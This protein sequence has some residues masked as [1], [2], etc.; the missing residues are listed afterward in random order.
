M[1]RSPSYPCSG[2]LLCSAHNPCVVTT[3]FGPQIA[4]IRRTTLI[5]MTFFLRTVWRW[6]HWVAYDTGLYHT[7]RDRVRGRGRGRCG[8]GRLCWC[9]CAPTVCV[10]ARPTDMRVHST[11]Q[12][13]DEL[14]FGA[15]TWLTWPP[16]PPAK[17]PPAPAHVPSA[18][19]VSWQ[20]ASFAAQRRAR[21]APRDPHCT[22]CSRILS[23]VGAAGAGGRGRVPRSLAHGQEIRKRRELGTGSASARRG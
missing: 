22:R 15:C 3:I 2:P 12:Q 20:R 4:E 14:T 8:L 17:N 13:C 18:P 23:R 9:W 1:R 6:K 21:R 19:A 7:R 10:L 16:A 11:S 5:L